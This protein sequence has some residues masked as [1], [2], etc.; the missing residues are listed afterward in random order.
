MYCCKCGSEVSLA[1]VACP[2]CGQQ[3]PIVLNGP[4][5]ADRLSHPY[6][7]VGGWL[8]LFLIGVSLSPFVYARNV[9][10]GYQHSMDVFSHS[11]HPNS[12]YIFYAMET[13]GGLVVYGYGLFA[14]IQLWRIRPGAVEHAKRF[15]FYLFCFGAADYLMGLN[16][17]A[18]MGHEHSSAIAFSNFLGGKSALK[19]SRAVIYIAVWYAYFSRSERVRVTYS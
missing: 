14:G 17:I 13:L 3:Q 12:L 5:P 10:L 2:S 15:L 19:L 6:Y 18:V 9:L 4:V 8:W 11:A 7:G 1:R 16:W